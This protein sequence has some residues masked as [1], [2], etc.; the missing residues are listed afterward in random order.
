MSGRGDCPTRSKAVWQSPAKEKTERRIGDPPSSRQALRTRRPP[1]PEPATARSS[2]VRRGFQGRSGCVFYHTDLCDLVLTG[3]V[4]GWAILRRRQPTTALHDCC[5]SRM[6]RISILP[7]SHR[8]LL[9]GNSRPA[10]DPDYRNRH[11]QQIAP[12]WFPVGV[13]RLLDFA[14]AM[15]RESFSCQGVL[16]PITPP[17]VLI[18]P[19]AA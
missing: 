17:A 15:A 1:A 19:R 4:D 12:V 11:L 8:I 13:R 10:E 5:T 2:L 18:A 14:C 9:M 3:Y 6:R 16:T 7:T